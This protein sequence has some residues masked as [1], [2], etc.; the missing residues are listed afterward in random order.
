MSMQVKQQAAMALAIVNALPDIVF[1][2]DARGNYVEVMGGNER[3]LYDSGN[4]LKGRNLFDVLPRE[5]AEAFLDTIQRAL[6]TGSLQ[7]I[8][9]DLASEECDESGRDGPSGPQWF[10]GRVFPIE[11]VSGSGQR[12][13]VVW[14]AVNITGRKQAEQEQERLIRE[15]RE[16]TAEV[17]T[18]QGIIPICSHCH[19]IRDDRDIWNRLEAYIQEH[20]QACFSHSIC[21]D[22][23]RE[24][25][26]EF[27]GGE[28]NGRTATKE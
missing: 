2:L 6:E 20:S 9:Y 13:Q 10:E 3:S 21:P 27:R 4:F 28:R 26:P 7:T 23:L 11:A 16:A 14:V 22:C 24:H 12:D 15:L 25:Y 5:R 17:T 19:K 1:V 18:L 8:E